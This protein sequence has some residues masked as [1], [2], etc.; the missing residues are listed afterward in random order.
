M[1]HVSNQEPSRTIGA[2]KHGLTDKILNG[3]DSRHIDAGVK[4]RSNP[5]SLQ[6][7]VLQS[8]VQQLVRV[9]LV[10]KTELIGKILW[11]QN[12]RFCFRS[13]SDDDGCNQV[14]I[15]CNRVMTV[16][17]IEV[18]EEAVPFLTDHMRGNLLASEERTSRLQIVRRRIRERNNRMVAAAKY[19]Y[20]K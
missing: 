11:Y 6:D 18:D 19:S 7:V 13:N 3:S 1:L 12:G 16:A 4:A 8:L 17:P 15:G 14:V 9:I 10:D 20:S 2:G 5:P